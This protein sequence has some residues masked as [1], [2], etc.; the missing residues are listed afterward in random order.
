[1]ELVVP[2]SVIQWIEDHV[3][4]RVIRVG[5]SIRLKH[6]LLLSFMVLVSGQ[7]RGGRMPLGSSPDGFASTVA[8]IRVCRIV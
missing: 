4:M 1:M 5:V 2:K 3:I 6:I 7:E 8:S